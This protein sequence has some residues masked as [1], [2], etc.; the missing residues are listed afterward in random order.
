MKN[1]KVSGNILLSLMALLILFSF[2]SCSSY[3]EETFLVKE[4]FDAI[5]IEGVEE[6]ILVKASD[7]GKCHV[8]VNEKKDGDVYHT[9][10]VERGVLKIE[11]HT[12]GFGWII[13]ISVKEEI[14][15]VQLPQKEYSSLMASS[16]SGRVLVERDLSFEKV[17]LS[18]TSGSVRFYGE[19]KKDI[20]L[21][22]TSGSVELTS[23]SILDSVEC[24]SV[25]GKVSIND[26]KAKNV[27]AKSSS[28]SVVLDSVI[29]SDSLSLH[30][31]SGSIRINKCDGGT[32]YMEST[33]GSIRGT[34]LSPKTIK[35]K[36]TSGRVE[37]PYFTGYGLC[38]AYTTSGNIVL[39]L[40]E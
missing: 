5:E 19:A 1:R 2:A 18:S 31:S 17:D 25:S 26:V 21:Q 3:K 7:D 6:G 20:S 28:G 15:E 16:T 10:E 8:I 4:N 33:S 22:S 29:A 36:S 34:L 40:A 13:G 12:K 11:H 23:S 30:S 14:I 9:V 38:E 32:I 37:V 35:A 39:E 24:R 27:Y